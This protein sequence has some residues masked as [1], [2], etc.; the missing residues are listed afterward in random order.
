MNLQGWHQASRAFRLGKK[1][2]HALHLKLEAG[3]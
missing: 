3:F 1:H 2:T